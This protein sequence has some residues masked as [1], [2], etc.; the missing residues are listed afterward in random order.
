MKNEFGIKELYTVKIKATSNIE[1]GN[2]TFEQGENIVVFDK[3]KI[4]NIEQIRKTV[5]A[6]GGYEDRDLIWWD[7]TK[8]VSIDFA[9]GIV[10][11]M[12]FSLISNSKLFALDKEAV[13]ILL[14]ARES[15]ESDDEGKIRL[16]DR[17]SIRSVFIYKVD[18]GEKLTY[19]RVDNNIY[20]IGEPFTEVIVDYN[21]TYRNGAD[22][23]VIGQI[24]T[25]GSNDT[26]W[27]EGRTKTYDDETGTVKTGI[28][29][30][31]RFKIVSHLLLTLGENANP[32][33]H[34]FSGMG[35]PY[36]DK[37]ESRV[38]EIF[39]LNDDIDADID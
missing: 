11:K 3:I 4:G 24:A 38:M 22:K 13:P 16:K 2:H 15:V 19:T 37:G 17:E 21:Y 20:Q 8:G 30:I 14:S 27:F 33:V 6:H 12:Q 1:I 5:T 18:T 36:G 34:K 39:Y 35:L 23:N 28:L 10:N 9:Q 25:S 7:T 29:V 32:M 26:L 31:P